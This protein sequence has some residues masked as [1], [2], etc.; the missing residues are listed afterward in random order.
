LNVYLYSDLVRRR[1]SERAKN[2]Q[3]TKDGRK[4]DR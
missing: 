3:K 1:K 4:L 2:K